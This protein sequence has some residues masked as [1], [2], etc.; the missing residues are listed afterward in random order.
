MH[1]SIVHKNTG[2][3][4]GECSV[5]LKENEIGA[6][7]PNDYVYVQLAGDLENIITDGNLIT[8]KGVDY[9]KTHYDFDTKQW[10]ISYIEQNNVDPVQKKLEEKNKLIAAANK[11]LSIPDLPANVKTV[12]NSYIDQLNA[13]NIS[14]SN[15]NQIIFPNLPV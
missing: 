13:I 15:S 10:N 9:T 3:M 8:P 7:V 12:L 4:Y 5:S 11:K 14:A 6:P 2:I 1:Y